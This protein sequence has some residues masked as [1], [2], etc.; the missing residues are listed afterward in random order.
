MRTHSVVCRGSMKF[1]DT[2]LDLYEVVESVA[3]DIRT[4]I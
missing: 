2:Y 4:H 3:V 1:E